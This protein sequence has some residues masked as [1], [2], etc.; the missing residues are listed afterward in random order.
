MFSNNKRGF[1]MDSAGLEA[2][3]LAATEITAKTQSQD[4][5]RNRQIHNC[6][7]ITHAGKE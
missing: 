1:K 2:L 3:G 4:F 5:A 6:W 7:L